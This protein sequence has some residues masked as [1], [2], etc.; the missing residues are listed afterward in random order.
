D[1]EY[2]VSEP[3]LGTCKVVVVTSHLRG[4]TPP[5]RAAKGQ[6]VT[7]SG[8]M[9]YQAEVGYAYTSILSKYEKLSTTDLGVIVQ[10]GDQT[11]NLMLSAK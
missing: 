1:G 7:G 5:P 11:Q 4:M 6:K 10:K 9:V 3:P 2:R 8:G